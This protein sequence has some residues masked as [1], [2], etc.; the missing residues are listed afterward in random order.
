MGP[1][2]VSLGALLALLLIGHA[3]K[4]TA[5]MLGAGLTPFDVLAIVASFVPPMLVFALPLA[6]LVAV[7]ISLG[8]MA[9]DGELTAFSAAGASAFRLAR[10]PLSCG[11]LL[12]VLGLPV[13]HWLQP[14]AYRQLEVTLSDVALRNVAAELTRDRIDRVHRFGGLVI[15]ADHSEDPATLANLVILSPAHGVLVARKA[16]VTVSAQRLEL[17]AFE[18]ELHPWEGSVSGHYARTTFREARVVLD[19]RAD[20]QRLN[21]IVSADVARAT[22]SLWNEARRLSKDAPR[23][24]RLEKMAARRTSRPALAFVFGTVGA[25]IGLRWSRRRWPAAIAVVIVYYAAM[26]ITD[27]LVVEH[28][29]WAHAAVW[30]PHAVLLAVAGWALCSDGPCV[31]GRTRSSNEPR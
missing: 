4:L 8:R 29:S 5:A 19:L 2:V 31:F 10:S 14:A 3:R 12:T 20:L 17:T 24:G 15:V 13:A 30:A 11:L 25:A 22:P 26:R 23:R 27:A 9:D 1:F 21:R 6:H 16:E 18:G 7:V 28:P